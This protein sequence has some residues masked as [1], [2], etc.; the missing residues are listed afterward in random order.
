M[1]CIEREA[2]GIRAARQ[3]PSRL[4]GQGL[5][6]DGDD[7]AGFGLDIDVHHARGIRGHEFRRPGK[8]DGGHDLQASR[9]RVPR[10]WMSPVGGD[11]I[12]VLR[13]VQDGIGLLAGDRH[14]LYHPQCV[15]FE[16]RDGI[17]AAIAGE[18]ALQ[19]RREGDAMNARRVRN[20]SR[21]FAADGFDDVHAIAAA[22]EQ[23]RAAALQCEVVPISGAPQCPA[24][25]H[26]VHGRRKRRSAGSRAQ[27][28]GLQQYV[29]GKPVNA[30]C[31][32]FLSFREFQVYPY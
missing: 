7:L 25:G 18:A 2:R 10:D 23:P 15:E 1:S 31:C 6:V 28:E 14:L 8:R 30:Q 16:D 13:F 22:D 24:C 21:E 11:H 12:V 29:P 32:N 20:A 5:R 9:H 17:A 3:R 27:G 26:R 19:R 4:H